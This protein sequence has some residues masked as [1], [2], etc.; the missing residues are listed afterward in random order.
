LGSTNYYFNGTKNFSL[1]ICYNPSDTNK[2]SSLISRYNGSVAGSYLFQQNADYLY[3]FR[4][5]SPW[6]TPAGSRLVSGEDYCVSETYDGSYIRVY[7][8][9][10]LDATSAL[11]T[12]SVYDSAVTATIAA[13]FD[14]NGASRF[15]KGKIYNAQIYNRALSASE[16]TTNY[17]S[18]APRQLV[19]KTNYTL[20]AWN[21]QSNGSG[22]SYGSLTTDLAA[23]PTPHF[24]V[25]AENYSG[26]TL[27]ASVG[28]SN[29][30][31][32][33]TGTPIL[34]SSSGGGFGANARFPTISGTASDGFRLG[35]AELPNYTFCGMARYKDLDTGVRSTRGRIF[36]HASTTNWLSGWYGGGTKNFF[37]NEW[38][39]TYTDVGDPK[40]HVMCESG[41]RIYWDGVQQTVTNR[42][43]TTLPPLAINWAG[44]GDNSHFEF[45]EAIVYNQ[46]LSAAQINTIFRY[47]E[48]KFG[49]TD[50]VTTSQ[51]AARFVPPSNYASTG[52][53]T[54]QATWVSQIT[55]DGNKQ[56]SGTAPSTQTITNSGGTV[57]TVGTLARAGYVFTGWNTAANGS[58]TRYAPGAAL[59]ND[60]NKL[61]YAQ[62]VLPVTLPTAAFN[63]TSLNPYMRL[64]APN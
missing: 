34:N 28:G 7:I 63:P 46:A 26:G 56:T 5:V 45:T 30:S 35:N 51:S 64:E 18:M 21:T 15:L 16:I 41:N 36:A 52:D 60:G 42:V 3:G 23:L 37:H 55:Y 62:W 1:S 4:E 57:A 17:Q 2:V 13:A 32:T 31:I 24:R 6:S 40:W 12:G 47:F 54:L 33:K 22:T 49:L 9:G 19:T 39:L 58:G 10:N 14:S 48:N 50:I 25:S 53:T 59:T 29:L 8:N 20:G 61:L 43:A 44:T 27:S 11:I 38:L